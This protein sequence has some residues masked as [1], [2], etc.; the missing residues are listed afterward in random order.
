[1]S[2]GWNNLGVG[3]PGGERCLRNDLL[4]EMCWYFWVCKCSAG[5]YAWEPGISIGMPP[6]NERRRYN[7]T[8]SLIGWAHTQTDPQRINS[9]EGLAVSPIFLRPQLDKNH[10][11]IFVLSHW[12]LVSFSCHQASMYELPTQLEKAEIQ[13]I[14]ASS[15]NILPP[16]SEGYVFVLVFF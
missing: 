15:W 8:T 6:A 9:S 13:W 14:A 2:D 3:W 16:N 1:M 12:G 10:H 7:V 11:K 4:S 5:Q